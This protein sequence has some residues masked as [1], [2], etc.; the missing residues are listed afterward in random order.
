MSTQNTGKESASD[1]F[2]QLCF[3]KWGFHPDGIASQDGD[4]RTPYHYAAQ[5][6]RI[7]VMRWMTTRVRGA[8]PPA[9]GRKLPRSRSSQA[10]SWALPAKRDNHKI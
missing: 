6:G 7:D 4:G 9:L 2:A 5:E 8:S 10:V 1:E 3:A